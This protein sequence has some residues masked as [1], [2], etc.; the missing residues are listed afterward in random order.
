M[1]VTLYEPLIKKA[2]CHA[3]AE[4]NMK[5]GQVVILAQWHSKNIKSEHVKRLT[6]STGFCIHVKSS[7]CL[8]ETELQKINAQP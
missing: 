2:E 4:V 6:V 1:N 8:R 5:S 3:W 7:N